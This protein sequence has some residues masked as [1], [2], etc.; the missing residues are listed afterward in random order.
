MRIH[1][2]FY[3]CF[4]NLL[5]DLVFSLAQK[6]D[7][8]KVLK[9]LVKIIK[10]FKLKAQ[11]VSIQY[12]LQDSNKEF[13]AVEK[14]SFQIRQGEFA[15]IVGPSG[16]GKSSILNAIAGLLPI[17][18][19]ELLLNDQPI[20][21]PSKNCAMV[22]QSPA[23]MPWRRVIDNVAYGL[24]IQGYSKSDR[25]HK[26]FEYLKLVGL[27]KFEQSF[28][29]QLSGG[30][31]QRVNL[32]RALTVEPSLLLLDEPFSALDALTREYMQEELQRIWLSTKNTIVYIT[33]LIDEAI[34]LADKILVMSASPG[35]IKEEVKIDF[36]RQ[37]SLEL[38]HSIEFN[39]YK[40][41]IWNLLKTES[42]FI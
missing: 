20:T 1:I 23:L 25:Y 27:Q 26:A 11:N 38:K 31:Q 35:K 7:K 33:H 32:A 24:E 36:P 9:Y 22:F 34:F 21:K 42:L 6:L 37:R 29:H 5:G 18:T 8:L 16:C 13:T 15:V 12:Q 39:K 28:P 2:G 14:I 17:S 30:M 4:L 3:L 40:S 10:L 41:Y 19:G